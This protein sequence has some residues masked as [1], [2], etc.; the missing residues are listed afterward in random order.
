MTKKETIFLSTGFRYGFDIGYKG[1]TDRTDTA[2]NL[3]FTVGT[4]A[5]LW[6]KMI[7]E[8]ELHRFVGP[9]EEIPYKRNFIQS[10]VGLVPK[11]GNKL[12]LIFHLSYQFKNGNESVNYWTPSELCTVK[13]K[14]LDHAVRMCLDLLQESGSNLLVFGKSDLVSA[15]R[16]LP[17]LPKHR[18]YLIMKAEHPEVPGKFFYFI[19]KCLPFGASISCSHFQRFSDALTYIV[20][21]R[22]QD[23]AL[24]QNGRISNYLD[25]FLFIYIRIQGCNIMIKIFLD[26][27][28]EI[29][30]PV[31]LEK[32]EWATELI[33]FLGILLDGKRFRLAISED[34]RVEILNWLQKFKDRKKTTVKE[35]QRLTGH[36]NFLNRAIVPGRTFTRRMYAKFSGEAMLNKKGKKLKPYHHIRIDAEFRRDCLM[37]EH[38]LVDQHAVNRPFLDLSITT[39]ATEIC[40]YSDASANKELG[41]GAIFGE[42]WLFGQWEPNFIQSQEPSIGFLEL[43]ALCAGIFTWGDQL[44]NS[45]IIVFCDNISA[46]YMVNEM[47]SSCKFCMELLRLL[48]LNNLKYNR[49]VFIRHVAGKT[50]ILSDALSRLE[51]A[52]FFRLAPKGV[53]EYPDKV[54]EA[55]WPLFPL[56]NRVK[57]GSATFPVF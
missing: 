52:K 26:T 24:D 23:Q 15:F 33:I 13:Y 57:A 44:I 34:R 36:L 53:N 41:Y 18:R 10:P 35:L 9:F 4:K 6:G 49:R 21:I 46:V 1:P 14:D 2:K 50:N 51:F 27:C 45:R 7:K 54:H 11:A 28:E 25:D 19:D 43:Y 5:D 38:F 37:W 3:P 31:S 32:T 12:R 30:F 48:T 56:W 22:V 20:Q 39:Q 8:V 42:R 16:N 29:N 40:F 55:I 47:T 17:I